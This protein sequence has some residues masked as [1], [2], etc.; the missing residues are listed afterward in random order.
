[1]NDYSQMIQNMDPAQQ[2]SFGISTLILLVLLIIAEWKIFT[3]AGE[4]GWYSLIPILR[5]YELCKIVDGKGIKFLLLIIPVVNVVYGI[6]LNFRMAKAY[7][8]GTGFALG[9]IFLPNIFQL[10]L[11]FGSAQYVGPRGEQQHLPTRQ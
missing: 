9:L 3:K 5:E 7:G 8:K 1:M 2:K 6:L 4:K 11:G 10:I